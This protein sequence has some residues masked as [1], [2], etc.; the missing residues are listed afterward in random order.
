MQK[1]ITRSAVWKLY[2]APT[3]IPKTETKCC[4]LFL[5]EKEIALLRCTYRTHTP[6][7]NDVLKK[8]C[9]LLLHSSAFSRR[10]PTRRPLLAHAPKE[11]HDPLR[12]ARATLI[13]T[14]I[15]LIRILELP[16]LLQHALA[17]L[18]LVA[19][20]ALRIRIVIALVRVAGFAK[21]RVVG[22]LAVRAVLGRGVRVARV[23]ELFVA[24]GCGGGVVEVRLV[25]GRG[26][27]TWCRSVGVADPAGA[28]VLA[29]VESWDV[30]AG[31][32]LAG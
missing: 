13:P 31:G 6:A 11:I 24:D 28:V 15:T 22:G 4:M 20:H 32:A 23:R 14:S 12:A 26:G 18:L 2:P 8:K 25:R 17:L 29:V 19:A 9:T 27:R 21:V 30:A 16:A 5:Q 3:R 1:I 7:S 10:L